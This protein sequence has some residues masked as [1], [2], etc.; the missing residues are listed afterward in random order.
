MY[1]ISLSHKVALSNLK[2]HG[3]ALKCTVALIRLKAHKIALSSLKTH[4]VALKIALS[5][6]KVHKVD[7][8]RTK[9]P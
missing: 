2:I 7:L 5:R 8:G 9:V 1:K 3:D 6:L 4:K